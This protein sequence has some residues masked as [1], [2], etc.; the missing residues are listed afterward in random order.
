MPTNTENSLGT[1]REER[2]KWKSTT[3]KPLSELRDP[4]TT[5]NKNIYKKKI[6]TM[7]A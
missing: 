1:V 4:K 6:I 5:V 3:V 7:F 2:K